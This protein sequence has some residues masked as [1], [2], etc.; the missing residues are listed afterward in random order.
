VLDKKG[1]SQF[2]GRLS[3]PGSRKL[4]IFSSTYCN[5]L[6]VK[7]CDRL[8]KVMSQRRKRKRQD[9][10]TPSYDG[11]RIP[12]PMPI[13]RK[14]SLLVFIRDTNRQLTIGLSFSS[15][16]HKNG[17]ARSYAETSDNL[18]NVLEHHNGKG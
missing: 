14:F 3:L 4:K 10:L 1:Y 9:N 8:F 15:Q 6:G 16:L 5:I 7:I 17:M 18:E 13:R 2:G 12:T 11:S